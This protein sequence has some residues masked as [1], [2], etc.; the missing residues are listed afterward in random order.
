MATIEELEKRLEK[1]EAIDDIERLKS[2]YAQIVDGLSDRSFEECFTEDAVWDLGEAGKVQGR[3]AIGELFK[4]VPEVQPFSV[5]YFVQAEI[6]V[7][8]DKAVGTWYEWLA[9]TQGDGRAVWT[10]GIENEEYRKV[11]GQWLISALKLTSIFR[12]PYEEG[13]HKKKFAD[14]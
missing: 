12:T 13:W 5:H 2:K 4:K 7:N 6:E 1:L 8:G 3:K 11:D 9:A 14:E 10:A